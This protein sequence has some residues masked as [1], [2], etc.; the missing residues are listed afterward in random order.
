MF[1]RKAGFEKARQLKVQVQSTGINWVGA[2]E[3][4][5]V[6]ELRPKAS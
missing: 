3:K 1:S 2:G 5:V 4:S 6:N